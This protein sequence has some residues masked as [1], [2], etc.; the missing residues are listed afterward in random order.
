[1]E[2]ALRSGRTRARRQNQRRTSSSSQDHDANDEGGTSSGLDPDFCGQYKH[3]HHQHLSSATSPELSTSNDAKSSEELAEELEKEV[4]S[5]YSGLLQELIDSV[6][7]SDDV[8][9]ALRK[10]RVE[11]VKGVDPL[12][13]ARLVAF[14]DHVSAFRKWSNVQG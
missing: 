9:S 1:M 5:S 13:D 14:D 4:E 10:L 12:L 2:I 11:G 3:Q 7:E 6:H 8:A